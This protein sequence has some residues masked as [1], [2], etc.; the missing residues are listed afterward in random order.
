MKSLLLSLFS[1]FLLA[2]SLM[3]NLPDK[4]KIKEEEKVAPNA[5]VCSYLSF[6]FGIKANGCTGL[7][8]SCSSIEY[9]FSL[10]DTQPQ[11]KGKFKTCLVFHRED[12]QMTFTQEINDGSTNFIVEKDTKIDSRFS[13]QLGYSEVKILQG[14]YKVKNNTDG[15]ATVSFSSKVRK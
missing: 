9:E 3:A 5:S 10:A 12:L 8:F 4:D 1:L 13:A 2:D 6:K 11:R 7:G 14:T 15:T